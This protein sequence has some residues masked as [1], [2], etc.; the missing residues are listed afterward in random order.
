VYHYIKKKR[1]L[2]DSNNPL[3]GRDQYNRKTNT[4]NYYKKLSF[5]LEHTKNRELATWLIDVLTM[6][7][8][9]LAHA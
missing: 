7:L 1:S 4:K 2:G 6:F 9:Y 3:E 8:L 5:F